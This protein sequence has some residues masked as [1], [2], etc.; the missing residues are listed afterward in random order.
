ML[1]PI[2]S[3]VVQFPKEKQRPITALTR[4]VP[5]GILSG[6]EHRILMIISTYA[7]EKD[8]AWP[9]QYKLVEDYYGDPISSLEEQLIHVRKKKISSYVN[10]L[11][12]KQ[13]LLIKKS[14][15]S[16]RYR[17]NRAIFQYYEQL[18]ADTKQFYESDE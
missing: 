13:M 9:S 10:K 5:S 2:K 4:F 14:G 3:N 1:E 12:E 6:P 11:E 17:I 15:R 8:E 16:N 18:L 7:N